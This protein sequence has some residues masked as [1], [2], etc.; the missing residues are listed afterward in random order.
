MKR[1]LLSLLLVLCLCLGLCICAQAAGET[2]VYDEAGL[3]SPTEES[4]LCEKLEKISSSYNAQVLIVTVS[5]V[6]DGDLDGYVE[7]LYDSEDFGYGENRDGVLLLLSMDP[8]EYRILSDG[9]AADAITME[10]IGSIAASIVSDLSCSNY[11]DAFDT[12]AEECDYY[13]NGYLNGFSFKTGTR[14]LISLVVGLVIG[15]I[16]V[17][18]LKRQLKSVRQQDQANAYVKS[19]SMQLTHSSDLYLYRHVSRTRR[20]TSRSSSRSGGGGSRNV[21]GGRF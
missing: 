20:E 14:L 19:G 10:D 9:F 12:F 4:E 11:A 16:V 18:V 3:L 15:L 8:R 5:S 13:L 21:G 17:L 1:K 6:P 7:Y 2:L